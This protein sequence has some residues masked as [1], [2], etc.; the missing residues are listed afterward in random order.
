MLA[1]RMAIIVASSVHATVVDAR[2][3][4]HIVNPEPIKCGM[5]AFALSHVYSE[6]HVQKVSEQSVA[7]RIGVVKSCVAERPYVV[8]VKSSRCEHSSVRKVDKD[9]RSWTEPFGIFHT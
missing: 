1:Y 3:L 4:T 9:M 2:N 7:K 8:Y 6:R 5:Y